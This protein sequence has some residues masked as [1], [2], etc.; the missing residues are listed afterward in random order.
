MQYLL[1]MSHMVARDCIVK[2][3]TL[4]RLYCWV[5]INALKKP[6]TFYICEKGR[7][8][9]CVMLSRNGKP[10][11][12]FRAAKSALASIYIQ[13]DCRVC[14]ASLSFQLG[15]ERWRSYRCSP[16]IFVDVKHKQ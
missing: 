3:D 10:R 2:V 13:M 11:V 12:S 1:Y 5:V 16:S 14:T 7:D 6:E 4:R 9:N 15:A 8:I